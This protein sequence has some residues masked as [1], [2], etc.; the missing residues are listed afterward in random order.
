VIEAES[1]VERWVAVPGALR[2][3]KHG[4]VWPAQDIL[5]THV[6]V[7]QSELGIDGVVDERPQ[8]RSAV[9]VDTRCCREVRLEPDREEDVVGGKRRGH[10]VAPCG[11][12]VYESDAPADFRGESRIDDAIAQL[13]FPHRILRGREVFHNEHTRVGVLPEDAR[14]SRAGTIE[15]ALRI[16][17][18]SKRLRS[19]GACQSALTLSLG[20]ARLMHTGPRARSTRTM[21]E[22]TPPVSDVMW[23]FSPEGS[24]PMRASV[25]RNSAVPAE[26]APS[27]GMCVAFP[28]VSY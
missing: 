24:R 13:L 22:E 8:L 2:V 6:A 17:S 15:D 10:V 27:V 21:S 26:S 1:E 7:Y 9:G 18:P 14:H 11:V 25:D 12:G 3:Q 20:N 23:G 19:T 28:G 16:H 4:T 5:W